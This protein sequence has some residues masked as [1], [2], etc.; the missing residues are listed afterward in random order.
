MLREAIGFRNHQ[1]KS[2]PASRSAPPNPYRRAGASQRI[3]D[4]AVAA[5]CDLGYTAQATSDFSSDIAGR[6]D[7]PHIDLVSLGGQIPPDRKDELK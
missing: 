6:F 5:L 1:E 4:E 3:L 7:V 2:C